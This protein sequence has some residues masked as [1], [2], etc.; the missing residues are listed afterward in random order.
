M[1]LLMF[2]QFLGAAVFITVSNTIFNQRL[3]SEL[4]IHAPTVDPKIIFSAGATNFRQIVEKTTI[5]SVILAY[6]NSLSYVYYV[7]AAVGGVSIFTVWG[8]G[9]MDIREKKKAVESV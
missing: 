2:G 7:A 9:W 5:P 4:A 6:A 8:M 3:I 1:S